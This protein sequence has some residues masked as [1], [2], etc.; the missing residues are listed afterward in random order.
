M[1]VVDHAED[2]R[3]DDEAEPSVEQLW[4][5]EIE[6]RSNRVLTGESLGVPWAAVKHRIEQELLARR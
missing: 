6:R 3:T 5:A 2:D 4:A 1:M